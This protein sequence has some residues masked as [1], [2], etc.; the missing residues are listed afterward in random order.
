[1]FS[2]VKKTVAAAGILASLLI[3]QQALAH[4]HLTS[5]L[6]ADKSMVSESPTTLT[7]TFTEGIEARFSGASIIA[8]D[9]NKIASGKASVDDADNKTLH[10][11]VN[12]QLTA[13]DYRVDWHVLS[14]DGHKTKG[15]YTFSLK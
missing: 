11:P 9:G 13:G 2:P 1:M 14:V 3:S 6:P 5:A 15:S 7:L 8:A 12:S 4:A 10:V